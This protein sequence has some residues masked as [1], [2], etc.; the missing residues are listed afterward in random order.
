MDAIIK[1]SFE[2]VATILSETTLGETAASTSSN[3]DLATNGYFGAHVQVKVAF[4]AGGTQNVTLALFS[5][6]DAGVTDD[7]IPLATQGIPLSAGNTSYL[8]FLVQDVAHFKIYA[9]HQAAEA[10]EANRAKVTITSRVWRHG[11]EEVV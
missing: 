5:S 6:L 9:W 7:N 8:S 4:A 10:T 1:R 3:V 11:F 2:G